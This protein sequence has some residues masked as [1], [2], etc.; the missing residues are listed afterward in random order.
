VTLQIVVRTDGTAGNIQV[1]RSLGGGLDE[2]AIEAIKQWRFRP[3]S[4]NGTPVDVTISVVIN[5][6]LRDRP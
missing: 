3:A 2:A 4:R 5:F 1:I 6:A